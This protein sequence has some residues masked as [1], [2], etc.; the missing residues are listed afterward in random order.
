MPLYHS[1]VSTCLR[2]G[3]NPARLNK[4]P[5][6]R[7]TL[8]Q[9]FFRHN[10]PQMRGLRSRYMFYQIQ[11]A[12]VA[13]SRLFN[14]SSNVPPAGYLRADSEG[15][16]QH[17]VSVWGA[18]GG[19]T[20]RYSWNFFLTCLREHCTA[21]RSP[22]KNTRPSYFRTRTYRSNAAASFPPLLRR[23][24]SSEEMKQNKNNYHSP[25]LKRTILVF[26]LFF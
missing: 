14:K 25:L 19:G 21:D 5:P 12:V 3:Q 13:S 23:I 11:Q 16:T 6:P 10:K 26:C 22:V 24:R 9:V 7:C 20:G 4:F 8:G 15:T 2:V 17:G 1:C 18:G